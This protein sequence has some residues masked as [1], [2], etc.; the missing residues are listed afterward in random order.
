MDCFLLIS[1][2]HSCQSFDR[3]IAANTSEI[4][5]LKQSV[6]CIDL[7]ELYGRSTYRI[8]CIDLHAEQ[9]KTSRPSI[10]SWMEK[11]HQRWRLANQRAK[12]TPLAVIAHSTSPREVVWSGVTPVFPT[13]DM[14]HFTA[15]KSVILM[16][17][18]ILADMVSAVGY[19]LS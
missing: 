2:F 8:R 9:L 5:P 6:L 15:P 7:Q 3:G 11:A 14:I 17:Q 10:G 13:D 19:E 4:L 16:D 1:F 12:V 18:A